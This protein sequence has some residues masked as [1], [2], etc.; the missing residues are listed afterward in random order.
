MVRVWEERSV[1]IRG[2]ELVKLA[3]GETIWWMVGNALA[4]G[5]DPLLFL[6]KGEDHGIRWFPADALMWV[7]AMKDELPDVSSHIDLHGTCVSGAP[8]EFFLIIYY[9]L[10][11]AGEE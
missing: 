8:P 10:G 6:G 7:P 5:A 1:A 4:P 3:G 9:I 2:V 11:N